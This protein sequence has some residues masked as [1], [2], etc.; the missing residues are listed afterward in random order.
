MGYQV[1]D[2]VF[3]T[4]DEVVTWAWNEHKIDFN[5]EEDLT[6]GQ[7]LEACQQLTDMVRQLE[8]V[9]RFEQDIM[10]QAPEL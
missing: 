2:K 6:V 3:E 9:I 5:S 1:N 10:G 8:S 7:K 4:F